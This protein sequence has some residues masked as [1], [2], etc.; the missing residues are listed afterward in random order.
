MQGVVGDLQGDVGGVLLGHGGLHAVG[1]VGLLQLGGGVDQEP[2]AAQLGGHVG[3]LEGH[4]LL[5]ADGLAELN[6]LLGVLHGG[7]I[8]PLGDAQRLSRDADTA[9]VQGGHGDLEALALLAQQ[10]LLG[11]LHVVEVQLAGGGGTDAHFV[12]VLFKG[13][14]LPA[15]F[16]DEGGDAPGTDAG[17]GD[18]EDHIGVGLAAVGDKD[19]LAV[20][21]VVVPHVL[22]GGLGAAGV[23]AGI[24][25]G[26]AEGPH[27][28]A[29]A[30]IGQILFLLLLIA[31][32]VDGVGAQ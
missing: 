22:G 1:D 32:G 14:A 10:V 11:D 20:E 2:G 31:E 6:P 23:G 5:L 15:L 18:G 8:G 21:E 4:V 19:F 3:N 7:L 26:Q 24:G 13:K 30:Q 29:G 16:H 12:V 28:F 17:G 9:A 25:L 27:L